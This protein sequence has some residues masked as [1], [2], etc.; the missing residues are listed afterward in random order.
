[1]KKFNFTVFNPDNT[2]HGYLFEMT[3]VEAQKAVSTIN[4]EEGSGHYFMDGYIKE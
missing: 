4:L 1:M 3:R 2:I